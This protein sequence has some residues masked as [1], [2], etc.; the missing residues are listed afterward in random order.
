M[1]VNPAA[2]EAAGGV[3][4]QGARADGV[5]VAAGEGVDPPAHLVGRRHD[6]LV[7]EGDL[8]DTLVERPGSHPDPRSEPTVRSVPTD[9]HRPT[10]VPG[11]ARPAQSSSNWA[12]FVSGRAPSRNPQ[13]I[14]PR[15]GWQRARPQVV[16]APP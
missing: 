8:D 11:R 3:G 1:M 15:T 14:A 4:E 10:T 7:G 9:L 13:Q 12:R 5:E 2:V 6:G 16:V